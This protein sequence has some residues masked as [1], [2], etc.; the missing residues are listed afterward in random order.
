MSAKYFEAARLPHCLTEYVSISATSRK[1]AASRLHT[2]RDPDTRT[3]HQLLTQNTA[4][5]VPDQAGRTV[6]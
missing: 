3:A 4:L 5:N 2:L 6:N 1:I